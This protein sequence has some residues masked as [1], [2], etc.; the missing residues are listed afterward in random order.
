MSLLSGAGSLF[1]VETIES[2]VALAGLVLN[3]SVA[4]PPSPT[5]NSQ[6][7]PVAGTILPGTIVVMNSSGLAALATAPD[8]TAAEKVMPFVVFD[9][10]VD[11]SGAYVQ[12]LTCIAGGI[13]FTTALFEA[14][15]YTP[16]LPLTFNAGQITPKTSFSDKRQI[17]G[18]VGPAG[19]DSVAGVVQVVMPQSIGA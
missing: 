15:T 3:L 12:K 11:Y 5:V 6:G 19:Y 17:I 14:A 1:N 18:F 7:T 13:V 8:I 9:G 2:P 16:G 10:N 4:S